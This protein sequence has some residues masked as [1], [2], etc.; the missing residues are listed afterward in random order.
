[1]VAVMALVV[2]RWADPQEMGTEVELRVRVVVVLEAA[3]REG[4]L[5]VEARAEDIEVV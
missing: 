5:E 4:A 3:M 2:E 1:M